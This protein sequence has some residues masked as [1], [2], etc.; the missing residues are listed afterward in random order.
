MH[1]LP[2]QLCGKYNMLQRLNEHQ[3]NIQNETK[4]HLQLPFEVGP[5]LQSLRYL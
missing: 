4:W 2:N 5:H 1:S 3:G